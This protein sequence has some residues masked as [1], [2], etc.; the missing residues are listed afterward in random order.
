M[1]FICVHVCVHV[2]TRV[3]YC[4]LSNDLC[5][6]SYYYISHYSCSRSS[7]NTQQQK[8]LGNF[9]YCVLQ[10]DNKIVQLYREDIVT[11]LF[12]GMAAPVHNITL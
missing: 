7:C 9:C 10:D 12:N 1:E 8:S 2:Y 11:Q 4:K 3:H 6:S 5:S